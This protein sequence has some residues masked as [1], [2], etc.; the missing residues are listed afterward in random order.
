MIGFGFVYG[1]VLFGLFG[2]NSVSSSFIN[3]CVWVWLVADGGEIRFNFWVFSLIWVGFCL[4]VFSLL[5]VFAYG[6]FC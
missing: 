6:Y 2:D 1:F 4:W 3:G 5:M